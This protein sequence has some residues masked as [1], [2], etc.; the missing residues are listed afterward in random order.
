MLLVRQRDQPGIV[1]NIGMLLA[2]GGVNISFMTVSGYFAFHKKIAW[3]TRPALARPAAFC[4]TAP[5]PPL[6]L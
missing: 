3:T 4:S 1:G 6:M 5:P 2:K